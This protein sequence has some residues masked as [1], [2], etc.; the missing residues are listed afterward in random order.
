MRFYFHPAFSL[1]KERGANFF[2]PSKDLLVDNGA[3]IAFTGEIMLNSGIFES[4]DKI[5]IN[6]RERTDDVKVSWR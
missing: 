5:E 1:P 3:M 4:F 6:P 2:C